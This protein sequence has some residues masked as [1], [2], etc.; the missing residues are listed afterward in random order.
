MKAKKIEIQLDKPRN[1][2]MDLNALYEFEEATG[3][4]FFVQEDMADL[5]AKDYRALVWCLLRKEDPSLTIEQVGAFIDPSNFKEIVEQVT[6]LMGSM[7]DA[8]DTADPLP[9][10]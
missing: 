2:Q 9:V 8:E 4:S 1:L 5:K 3:K 6:L 7:A 10:K